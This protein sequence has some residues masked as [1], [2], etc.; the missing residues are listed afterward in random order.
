MNALQEFVRCVDLKIIFLS[1][2][3]MKIAR[4]K[5]VTVKIDYANGFYVQKE[6]KG[7]GLVLF[8]R[9]EVDVEIKSY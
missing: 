8:W 7:G 5:R 6:G 1:K 2:M 3:K 4:L 9:E